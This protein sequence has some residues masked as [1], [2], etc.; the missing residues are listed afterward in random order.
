MITRLSRTVWSLP[1]LCLLAMAIGGNPVLGALAEDPGPGL[2]LRAQPAPEIF[3]FVLINVADSDGAAVTFPSGQQI[4]LE[5]LIDPSPIA[6]VL[7]ACFGQ[8]P[9]QRLY[10]NNPPTPFLRS[11]TYALAVAS[12]DTG[13]AVTIPPVERADFGESGWYATFNVVA[14]CPDAPPPAT[15]VPVPTLTP[16]AVP[17][18]V[19]ATIPPT[20]T[21]TPVP[22]A[23]G[24]VF[25]ELR[26]IP[27]P[28]GETPGTLP[29]PVCARIVVDP[30]LVGAVLDTHCQTSSFSQRFYYPDFGTTFPLSAA[31]TAVVFSNDS[32]CSAIPGTFRE[33]TGDLGPGALLDVII[34]CATAT[35]VPTGTSAPT[36]TPTPTGTPVPTESPT[37]TGTAAPTATPTSVSTGTAVSTGTSVPSATSVPSSTPTIDPTATVDSTGTT[38]PTGTTAPT[39]TSVFTGTS[40]PSPTSESSSTP[41]GTTVPRTPSSTST[42]PSTTTPDPTE[43]IM[44]S[45]TLVS[46]TTPAQTSTPDSAIVG[47]PSTGSGS[48]GGLTAGTVTLAGVLL[49]ILIASVVSRTAHR[50]QGA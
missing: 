8:L 36:E 28:S 23:D 47:L 43:S 49:V 38:M 35:A 17:T 40:A 5:V 4:C 46:G 31:Y 11:S 2:A 15:E 22:D 42:S 21:P 26:F 27:G 39:A 1:L 6:G 37:P 34:D 33:V 12:N 45:P 41:H 18:D 14:D 30:P 3:D 50:R 48:R 10:G 9:G 32:G 19:P 24:Y 20:P 13:C 44:P 16:T 7:T 29:G 25:L